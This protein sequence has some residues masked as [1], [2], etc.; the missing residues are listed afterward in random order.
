MSAL[1]AWTF[2]RRHKRRGALLLSLISLVTAGL[3]LMG[4]LVWGVFVEPMRLSYMAL[5][6]FSIVT[7]ASGEEEP[8]AGP[9]ARM[10]ANPDVA[11]IIPTSAIMIQL[12]GIMPGEGYQ[13]E[14]YGLPERD[15][16]Y[17]LERC[18]ATL[19]AGDLPE[20]GTNGLLLSEEIAAILGLKVGDIYEAT[21]SQVYGEVNAPPEAV[22]FKVVGIMTGDV[23][24]GI[25]SLEFLHNQPA[26]QNFPARY[27]VV[28]RENRDRA[29]D[30]WLR[31]EIQSHVAEVKTLKGLNERI[32]GEA[33][34][35]FMLLVPAI[36]LVACAFALVVVAV[37]RVQNARRLPEFGIMNALGLGRRW[38]V[39]R[40]TMET[41][42]LALVGWAVGLGL[43]WLALALLQAALFAPRGQDLS[44]VAWIPILF[45]LPI[46]TAVIGFTFLSTRRHL[47]HL[48]PVSIVERGELSAEGHRKQ[49]QAA[50]TS[51]ARP[52]AS[53]TFYRRHRR[54]AASSV[55][56]MSL[57]IL[58]VA[59]IIFVL[60]IDA[61]AKEP[62]LGYLGRVSMVRSP[63]IVQGLEPGV[64][65]QVKAH[66]AVERVI[67]VAPRFHMLGV[68]IPPFSTAEASPFGVH[69]E[70]LAYLVDLYGLDLKEGRLPRAGTNEMVIPEIVARNRDLEVGD[71][72]GDPQQPPYPGAGSLPTQFVIS[73]VF[74]R[75][76]APTA[77][78]GLGF[79]SLEFLETHPAYDVPASPPLFVVPRAGQKEVVDHWLESELAGPDAAVLTHRQQMA[80]L[81]QNARSQMLA[82]ALLESV[83]AI[84]VALALAVLNHILVSQRRS[85]F[86]VLHALGYAR[87]QLVGRVLRETAFTTGIAWGLSATVTLSGMLCLRFV[88]FAPLGLTFNLFHLAPWLYTLPIPVAVLAVTAST[89]ARSLSGLDPVSI[90]ERR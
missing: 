4:A 77:G 32:V 87:R 42:A 46:P 5:S 2:Y 18:G 39:R 3:Y 15:T 8:D 31:G 58:A 44:Y 17:V 28:A 66:P 56:V 55:G 83:I 14:L 24:L 53:A 64:V 26:Y 74:A 35:G 41:A 12:P 62:L 40:L 38:L 54:R 20:P 21:S 63:A 75:P 45:A 61:D 10:R 19:K 7:L 25:V 67:P 78:D 79:V 49:A 6:R 76:P 65:A 1:S 85:E 11:R 47:A 34:P 80:G 88:I 27:L 89:T 86:G 52:L 36:L 59:L 48:D 70:D 9:S 57:M 13:F 84:V 29:V 72:I 73:G 50:G 37:N 90:V 68:Y 69:A 30:D 33:L 16:A 81:R 23:R 71:V 60:A 82:M 43:A 22:P 51:S